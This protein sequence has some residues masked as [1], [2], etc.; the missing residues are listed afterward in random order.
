VT[1]SWQ[2]PEEV[3]KERSLPCQPGM[4][5]P[6]WHRTAPVLHKGLQ[7]QRPL[8]DRLPCSGAAAACIHGS[9]ERRLEP[10]VKPRHHP[11]GL[12]QPLLRSGHGA[13]AAAAAAAA[14]P[15][16]PREAPALAARA[17]LAARGRRRRLELNGICPAARLEGAGG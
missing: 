15:C 6:A 4:V 10:L 14:S 5:S 8:A 1:Q 7:R 16:T 9:P 12:S 11:L 2:P 3:I 13:L 17:A